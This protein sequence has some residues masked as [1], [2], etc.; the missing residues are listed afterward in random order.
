MIGLANEASIKTKQSLHI[1]LYQYSIFWV[2]K[3]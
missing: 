1:M 2:I 3:M